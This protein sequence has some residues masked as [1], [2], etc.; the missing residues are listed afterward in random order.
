MDAAQTPIP[1]RSALFDLK[2]VLKELQ[3]GD[4]LLVGARGQIRLGDQIENL[5]VT[6][7]ILFSD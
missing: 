5:K 6:V 7:S 1:K 3:V 2:D 4:D